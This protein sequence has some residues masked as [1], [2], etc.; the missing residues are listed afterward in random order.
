MKTFQGYIIGIVATINIINLSIASPTWYATNNGQRYLIEVDTKLNWLQANN[1][2]KRRGLQLL[3]IENKEKN[4]QIKNI[5]LNIR[6]GSKDIWIGYHDAFNTDGD[7]YR[8]FYNLSSGLQITYSDWYNGGTSNRQPQDHCAQISNSNNLQW[9]STDCSSKNA[10]ICEEPNNVRQVEDKR[11][12]ILE[13]NH[14]LSSEFRQM[15][16]KLKQIDGDIRQDTFSALNKHQ[17]STNDVIADLKQSIEAI[18]KK[19][20][21]LLVLMADSI[22]TFNSLVAEKEAELAK[23]SAESRATVLSS[24]ARGQNSVNDLTTKFSNLLTSNTNEINRLL[25]S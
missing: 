25:T 11:E 10:F 12:Q 22:T 23:I 9:I 2:C 14:K 3:E 13:R 7:N 20:P 16:S 15:E 19:K 18:L 21:L 8:P 17:K 1:E 24:H 5:L 4:L 6:G